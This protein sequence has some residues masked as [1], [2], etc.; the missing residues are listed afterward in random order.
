M[1]RPAAEV[2]TYSATL[3]NYLASPPQSYFWAWTTARW[4]AVERSLFPGIAAIA[5]ALIGLVFRPRS[6]VVVYAILTAIVIE[7]SL[8]LNGRLYSWLF[9]SVSA[10]HGLRSPSRFGIVACATL[11]IPAGFGA[12]VIRDR[13]AKIGGLGGRAAA[14][15]LVTL[16]ALDDATSG[17]AVVEPPYQ[18]ASAFN[19]YKTIRALGPGP[20]LE[21]P[22]PRL[23]RLPG[24]EATYMLW[25]AAHW[26]PIVNGY[27]GY[28]PA[29]YSE[30]VV[31]LERFPDDRSIAQLANLGVRYIVVHRVYYDQ[32]EFDDLMKQIAARPELRPQG[33]YDDPLGECHLFVLSR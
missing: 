23:D 25:S 31:R 32:P 3:S 18:P 8:G 5:L 22:L 4:G 10:L 11:A 1:T 29:E 24:H 26:H 16:V 17:V 28:Y 19:V 27:S 30:T 2:A 15:A 14:V 7:L 20:I 9:N 12:L 6:T 13:L 33:T 21:L